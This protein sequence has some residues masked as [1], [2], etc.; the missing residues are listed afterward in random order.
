MSAAAAAGP[1]WKAFLRN[2]V[3]W[4]LAC[5]PLAY[6]ADAAGADAVE[7]AAGVESRGASGS[8]Q[9]FSAASASSG[10][11]ACPLALAAT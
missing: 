6:A 11:R 5:G 3:H 9:A 10:M 4:L 2:P 1:S 7:T 8:R